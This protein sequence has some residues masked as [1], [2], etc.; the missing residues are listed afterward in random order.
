MKYEDAGVSIDKANAFEDKLRN[1]FGK[2]IGPFGGT[3]DLKGTTLVTSTDGVGTKLKLETSLKKMDSAA[4]DLVAMNVNDIF[5]LGAKPLFF[6]DYIG[7]HS[8]NPEILNPFVDSLKAVLDSL[9]CRLLGGETAEM[10]SIYPE[11]T[12][13]LVGFVVGEIGTNDG[14][15]LGSHRVRA[16]DVA[17][18]L[19]SSG[20]HSN[21]YTLINK[22]IDDGLIDK[23]DES[24]MRALLE[25][26]FIYSFDFAEGMRACAHVT[27]GGLIENLPRMIPEGLRLD[28]EIGDVPEIFE[29]IKKAGK[30]PDG[31]MLRTFNMGTGFVILADPEKADSIMKEL[32][33]F[34]PRIAGKVSEDE[35]DS[36]LRLR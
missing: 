21:G 12:V 20:P 22:L 2:V 23:T 8:I 7:C 29:I 27:G 34:N 14:R 24:V 5:C 19:P 15:P 30:I 3:F 35:T 6:L 25:P 16:G 32:E 31:E 26:T 10:P 18:A 17:I 4:Q 1:A 11:N 28:F 33:I 13:D 36:R 9:D